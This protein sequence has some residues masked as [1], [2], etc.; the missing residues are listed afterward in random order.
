MFA[1]LVAPGDAVSVSPRPMDRTQRIVLAVVTL[2]VV[3]VSLTIFAL[4]RAT[5]EWVSTETIC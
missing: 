4:V 1:E 5:A 3:A 2:L